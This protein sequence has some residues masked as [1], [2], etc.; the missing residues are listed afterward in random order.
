MEEFRKKV[1]TRLRVYTIICCGSLGLYFTLRF[2]T[3]GASDFAQGLTMGVLCGME[4][5]AVFNLVRMLAATRNEE[6]LREMYINE[7]D[8]RNCAIQKATSQK[9]AA[10]SMVGT[11]VAAIVA[12]FFDAKI[13]MT[14]V[15]VLL[16]SALITVIVNAY[17]NK[18]M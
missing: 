3:K 4:F 5:V 14:L 16:V 10:I 2:L 17:Y 18:K 9:S 13:C 7:T 8:E 11:A 1:E 6:K 15:A 12:G